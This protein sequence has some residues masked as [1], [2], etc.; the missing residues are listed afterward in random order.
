M[1]GK[2]IKNALV[3]YDHQTDTLWS[4]FLSKGVKGHFAG[5]RLEIV[6]LIRT[7]WA[8]W[9]EEHPDTLALRKSGRSGLDPYAGYYLADDAGVIG[10]S[11]EDDR[12]PNKVK[13]L[14]IG[15]EQGAKA[16]PLDELKRA[17]VVND[18]VAG[19]EV[20]VTIDP[21]TETTFAFSRIVSGRAL[22]FEWA[23]RDGG[24]ALRDVETGSLWLPFSGLAVEG[25][26]KGERLERVN[27]LV[28][29]WF[30]WTDFHPETAL[31]TAEG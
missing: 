11:H 8:K 25:E 15:F 14:G 7:T 24:P 28:S 9:E 31:Y 2:L 29:F 3:M 23:T 17:K 27:G 12:L 5:E 4:Q 19:Q 6:P 10:E 26:L 22:E 30:A 20:A 16:Y 21:G 18:R 13:I 1:S